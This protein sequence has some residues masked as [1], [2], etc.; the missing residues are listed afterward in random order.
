MA[1]PSLHEREHTRVGVSNSKCYAN[2]PPI[3]VDKRDTNSW[4]EQDLGKGGHIEDS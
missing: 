1:P 4:V 2:I 3:V